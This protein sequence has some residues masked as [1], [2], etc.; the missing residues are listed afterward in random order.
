MDE[1]S[2]PYPRFDLFDLV[3]CSQINSIGWV[4]LSTAGIACYAIDR[5]KA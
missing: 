5:G 4:R 2:F 3:R 1:C